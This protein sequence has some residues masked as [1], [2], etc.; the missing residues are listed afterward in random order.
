MDW[1]GAPRAVW[2]VG[3]P[4]ATG[5][6]IRSQAVVVVMVGSVARLTQSWFRGK[7]KWWEERREK[8]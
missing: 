5:G 1:S 8:G 6:K 3:G 2:D 7:T 4:Q